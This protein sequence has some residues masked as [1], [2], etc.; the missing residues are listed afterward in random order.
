[1]KSTKEIGGLPSNFLT[2]EGRQ[3]C[4]EC[5]RPAELDIMNDVWS[6]SEHGDGREEEG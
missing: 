1:M 2:D 6:C 3:L 4:P 5:E